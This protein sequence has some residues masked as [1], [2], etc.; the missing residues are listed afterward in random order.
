MRFRLNIS[1]FLFSTQV[2][3]DVS[4]WKPSDT[5]PLVAVAITKIVGEVLEKNNLSG[6]IASLCVG[7]GDI[8][9]QISKDPRVKLVSFTGST[10]VGQQVRLL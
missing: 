8:G 1:L 10:G 6:A 4:V 7:R 9:Q 2:C 5:T 3:G